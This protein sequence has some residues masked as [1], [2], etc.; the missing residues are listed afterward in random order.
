MNGGEIKDLYLYIHWPFCESLCPYCDFNSFL[1]NLE[2]RGKFLSAY[3]IEIQDYAKDLSKTHVLKTIFF[4]GGTPSLMNENE[5][6]EILKCIYKCFKLDDKIEISFEANPSSFEIA[7]FKDF[8]LCG[9]NRISIGVQSFD[10]KNLKILGRRHNKNEAIFAIESACDIFQNTSFD[11]MFGMQGQ[12]EN[13]IISEL[14]FALNR[15]KNQ[16][17]SVYN[18]AIEKGTDFYAMYKRGELILPNE[19][20]LSNMYDASIKKMEEFGFLQYEVS[21]Y[22]KNGFKSKHNMGYWQIKDYIGIGSGAHGRFFID[23][24]R[25]EAMNLHSPL[26]WMEKVI[27]SRRGLQKCH[28]ISIRNQVYEVFLMS[29]RIFDGIDIMDIKNRLKIDILEYINFTKMQ[30]LVENNMIIATDK[31]IKPTKIGIKMVNYLV[32]CLLKN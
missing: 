18:L 27:D 26:K 3:L 25:F 24:Q 20:V 7:K 23:N 32:K 14:D 8:K 2:D 30:F 12:G 19:E 4:G 9:I 1:Y 13:E 11:L 10:E 31:Y 22:A 15:F 16:H 28:K 29:M 5:V 6:E 17:I 21:N